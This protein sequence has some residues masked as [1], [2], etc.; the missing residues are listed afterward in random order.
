MSDRFPILRSLDPHHARI[1]YLGAVAMVGIRGLDVREAIKARL[2]D[3]LFARAYPADARFDSL[4][5]RLS[6]ER[7]KSLSADVVSTR[8][9]EEDPSAI[10]STASNIDGWVY[11][12]EFWL[13]DDRMPSPLGAL[14]PE[15]TD[16]AIELARMTGVLLPT[17]ELSEAGVLLRFLIESSA[18][19][20][21]E[22][23]P[24]VLWA[25]RR[26]SLALLYLRLLLGNEMLFP[27]LIC[28][29]V[30]RLGANKKLA[31]RGEAG[32]LRAAVGRLR[33]T[34]GEP[35]DP[36]DMF[37]SR[38][39]AEFESAV[40]GKASTE[41]NYLRPRMEILVDLGF[42]GRKSAETSR[43][44]FRWDVTEVTQRIA[45]EWRKLSTAESVIP[46]Y[47]DRD[48]FGSMA[49]VLLPSH[50]RPSCAEE[51]L[52]WFVRAFQSI[53]REFGFT[54]GRTCALLGC[55]LAFEAG[56]VVEVEEL[57]DTVF[58]AGRGDLA[59][60]LHFS[61]GSRFDREFLIRIDAEAG[62]YL[63]TRIAGIS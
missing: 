10:L 33:D 6:P 13:Y 42:I 51:K 28:E 63:E 36:D 21:Q 53:G 9:A 37:A 1:G 45:R 43:N 46:Q 16:R 17:Y 2:H 24:N 23:D 47:L 11:V 57:F 50:A 59:K 18:S 52:L 7:W 29:M 30:D 31:T 3:L 20:A 61:G 19:F 14:S 15:K 44:E 27:F 26:P 58:E 49:R 60:Y 55:L 56:I 54:P 22:P 62:P 5:S 25:R 8:T 41:E 4:K 39:I 12:S 48:F 32:L 40:L 35:N 38:D 34:I